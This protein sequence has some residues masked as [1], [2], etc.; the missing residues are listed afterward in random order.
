MLW[1]V[2]YDITDNKRRTKLAKRMERYC[3]RVQKSIFECPLD[4]KT[5]TKQLEKYWIPLLN[6][7]EDN[8]RVY[9]LDE[10]AKSRTRVYGSPP[11]YEP[12]DY[13]VL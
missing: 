6:L 7:Q 3:E 4:D 2:C 13:I 8:L 5:I 12:P 1:L 11:P 10:T 9:P